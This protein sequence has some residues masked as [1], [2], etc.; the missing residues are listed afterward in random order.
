MPFGLKNAGATYQRL[1][2]KIFQNLSRSKLEV[3]IDDMLAKTES[4][5]QL[6]HDLKVIMN[7]LRK[8]QMRL[9]PAKC[10]FGMEAGKFL[11]FMITQR[12][13]EA[14]PEK[15]RVVLEMTS[16]KNLKDIQ[17]LTG[18]LTALSRFL[19]ASAQKAIPFFK[20]MKKGAP[21]KWETELSNNQAEYEALLAG[22][23]LARE[24]GAK[25][26]EVNTDSQVVSSQIN[27][28][29]QTRDPLL[30]QYL[31]KVNKLKEG[32]EHVTIQ[33]VPR[34]RNARADLLSKLAST[35]PGHGNKSL[36]QEVVKLPSVLTTTNTHLTFS[37]Q[38]SWTYPILQYLLDGTLPPDPKEGKRIKREAAK[39][40][41]VAG[42]LYKR[43][44]S[45]PLLKCV[46][47]GDTEY[48]LCEIHEDCC[49]HHVGDYYTKWIE[50]EPLASITATQCRKFLWRQIITRFGIPEIVISDNGTQ[51]ADKKF[52]EFLEGLLVSHCFSSVEHPQTNRQVESA[53][54]I[55][56]KGLKKWLDEAKGLW[57]DELGSV[58]WSYRTTPQTTM[59]ETPFRLTYGVE[60][61]IPVEIGDPSPRK[62]VGGND[63]E[64]ER[65]LID[66]ER[67]I[68][69]IKELALKQRISLRYNHS[70]VRREFATDD[71]VLRRNDIGP[72]TPGEG[73]L[74]PNWEGPYRIKAVIE[75]G[76][77]KLKRLNG[78]EVPRTWNAANLRR[79]YT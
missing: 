21:F 2:N 46:E 3:Y 60:A 54:K 44:F 50:A 52:R 49:G 55:I 31:A 27:G 78:N 16:P 63:E 36:I 14:N 38:G 39:Y 25:V 66:K 59:G 41:V 79:Y 65:D 67:S 8:H 61:V 43:G 69:H 51:F 32:F 58:L 5:E 48:I 35:K 56:V 18:R 71:L 47:P 73:K 76:A 26:L 53:N 77:Y 13:V 20:L 6:T 11:C 24:V 33:H 72:P 17:K 1:V 19:G 22:L 64:A 28:D 57:A 70:V 7:T 75:K 42:Q 37:N 30:Q 23:A 62:T 10:A 74:T 4:D 9:N 29:Y 15:C 40:T 68:A 34:K 45:Q 12:G